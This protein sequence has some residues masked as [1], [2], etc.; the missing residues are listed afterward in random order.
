MRKKPQAQ[1]DRAL[2][3]TMIGK[4]RPATEKFKTGQRPFVTFGIVALLS[5]GAITISKLSPNTD[6]AK[7]DA[8]ASETASTVHEAAASQKATAEQADTD[9]PA[10]PPAP[11]DWYMAHFGAETC[12]PLSDIGTNGQRVHYGAGAMHTPEDYVQMMV[13]LS[14]Q[15][16]PFDVHFDGARAYHETG[17][18]VDNHVLMFEDREVC[19]AAMALP[20]FQNMR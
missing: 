18:G 9:A 19:K 16:Q 12:V 7:S 13:S 8:E 14:T 6:P 2:K 20:Q 10:T 4:G 17:P 3:Q 15:M 11:A 5:L 1:I